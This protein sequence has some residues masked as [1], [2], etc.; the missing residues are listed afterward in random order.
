MSRQSQ[1]LLV[2][3]IL[4]AAALR[5]NGML[6]NTFHSDEALFSSWSRLIAVL[7]DPLL[8][9]QLIDKPPLLFYLQALFYPL[10][11][12]VMWAARLPNY[13]ASLLLI[14]LTA[15]LAWRM[16]RD[17]ST[18][19]LAAGFLVFSPLAIQYSGSAF[20]DPLMTCLIV[21][22]LV[23]VVSCRPPTRSHSRKEPRARKGRRALVAGVLFGL[24]VASKYQAWLFAPLVFGLAHANEWRKGEWFRWLTGFLP[25]FGLLLAWEL[26]RGGQFSLLENQLQSY[27]GVRLA[28]SWELWPRLEA[29]AG[30]WTH[31][32][33]SPVLEFLLLLA[34]P[35]FIALLIE[36]HDRPAALDRLLV[37]FVFAYFLVHWFIAVPVW[38]RYVLPILPLLGLVMAR[39]V[40]RVASYVRPTVSEYIELPLGS[41]HLVILIPLILIFFQAAGIVDAYNGN[42]PLGAR[43]AADHGAAEIS[44]ALKDAPY[45]T[46]LYDHWYSWQWRY[47]LFDMKVFVSWFPDPAALVEDLQVFGADKHPRYV[48]LPDSAAARPVFR[49]LNDA[50]FDLQRIAQAAG[51]GDE[52]GMVLY[53]VQ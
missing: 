30:Q 4:I 3:L 7:R 17:E 46:V 43:R 14:P 9:D 23:M 34:L 33:E 48:V 5:T 35:P 28:W 44:E 51:Q 8:Q 47:H 18:M 39:F 32:L 25:M 36:Q 29:W 16:Y 50:Q 6:F 31:V 49:A 11:G 13:I 38:D 15:V 40:W 1:A 19:I 52:P 26:G 42:L 41:K 21:A 2:M 12:P 20:I 37:L 24:A 10:M 53:Q 45:G 27:G 22:T